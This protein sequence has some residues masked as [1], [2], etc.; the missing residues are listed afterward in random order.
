MVQLWLKASLESAI[1]QIKNNRPK[2]LSFQNARKILSTSPLKQPRYKRFNRCGKAK[3][4]LMN[5]FIHKSTPRPEELGKH[6]FASPPS[7]SMILIRTEHFTFDGG[8][9]G[10]GRWLGYYIWTAAFSLSLILEPKNKLREIH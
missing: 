8:R 2:F 7:Y 6:C 5:L 3:F 10:G 4:C 1:Y 9:G